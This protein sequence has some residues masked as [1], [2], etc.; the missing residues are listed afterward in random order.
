MTVTAAN[1]VV[2]YTVARPMEGG[3]DRHAGAGA[4]A[5]PFAGIVLSDL[6]ATLLA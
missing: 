3:G 1:V 2:C 4:A 6:S 5:G